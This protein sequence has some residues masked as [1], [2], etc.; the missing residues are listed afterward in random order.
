MIAG[1]S[2]INAF[3]IN[4]RVKET[5]RL[6]PKDIER[7]LLIVFRTL[8]LIDLVTETLAR[9]VQE[10]ARETV[11]SFRTLQD[12]ALELLTFFRTLQDNALELL[13]VFLTLHDKDREL[14]TVTLAASLPS[15]SG[16]SPKALTPIIIR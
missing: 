16:E 2:V 3:Q 13:T 6:T 11:T 12:K 10:R 14:L 7:V 4:S 9:T 5:S 8:Q 1:G 15:P